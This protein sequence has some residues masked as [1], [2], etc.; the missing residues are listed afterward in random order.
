VDSSHSSQTM[1]YRELIKHIIICKKRLKKVWM[2][3]DFLYFCKIKVFINMI[4]DI[5]R[6]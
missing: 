4:F 5:R 1:T 2:I 3:Q 6:D